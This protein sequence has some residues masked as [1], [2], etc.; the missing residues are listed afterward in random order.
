MYSSNYKS[1]DVADSLERL[2]PWLE[3]AI[4]ISR[5]SPLASEFF[6]AILWEVKSQLGGVANAAIAANP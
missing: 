3:R 2:A 6:E 4:E 5:S 1:W